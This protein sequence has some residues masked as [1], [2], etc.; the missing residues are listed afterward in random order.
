MEKLNQQAHASAR[1]KSDEFVLEA[2]LTFDKLPTLVYD[3]ILS[4]QWREK[5]YPYL[6]ADIVGDRRCRSIRRSIAP[7]R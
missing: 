5:V 7:S 1:D 4:E 2:F 3:L 6:E